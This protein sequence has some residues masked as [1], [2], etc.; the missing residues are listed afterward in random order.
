MFLQN[1]QICLVWYH[2]WP[3][4]LASFYNLSSRSFL[5]RLVPLILE[6]IP[7]NCIPHHMMNKEAS[8]LHAHGIWKLTWHTRLSIRRRFCYI[9]IHKAVTLAV[10]HHIR[11]VVFKTSYQCCQTVFFFTEDAD[12]DNEMLLLSTQLGTQVTRWCKIQKGFSQRSHS[13]VCD[14]EIWT[15]QFNF[16]NSRF[17]Y[18]MKLSERQSVTRDTI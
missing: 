13:S 7:K 15:I 14:M 12:K 11:V 10:T 2:G 5:F 4:E 3:I 8:S 16:F 17:V 6:C 18:P 1:G 9:L